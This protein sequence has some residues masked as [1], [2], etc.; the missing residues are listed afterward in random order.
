M[1]IKREDYLKKLLSHKNDKNIKIVTGLRR[2]GKSTIL[3]QFKQLLL[4]KEQISKE[5]IIQFDFNDKYLLDT[6]T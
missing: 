5:Q 1:E 4:E 2:I 6:I 3:N